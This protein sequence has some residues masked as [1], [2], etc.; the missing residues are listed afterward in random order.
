MDSLDDWRA[1]WA[2]EDI[3]REVMSVA[4]PI[5]WWFTY[6][7]REHVWNVWHMFADVRCWFRQLPQ[8]IRQGFWDRE[9]WGLDTTIALFALPR[10]RRLRTL[11]QGHPGDLTM[12]QWQWVLHDIEKFLEW[13][14]ERDPLTWDDAEYERC[15]ALFGKYFGHLWW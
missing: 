8:R 3:K 1:R 12:E 11:N 13:H 6:R 5:R 10:L 2:A 15:G 4:S 7:L 9:T 14:I